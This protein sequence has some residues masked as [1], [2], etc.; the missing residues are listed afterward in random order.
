[1]KISNLLATTC[2][3]VMLLGC[4]GGKTTPNKTSTESNVET[5]ALK[6]AQQDLSAV[7]HA[8]LPEIAIPQAYRVDM[9]IDPQSDTMSGVVEIDVD[10]KI[11]DQLI[12]IHAKEMTVSKATISYRNGT[13]IDLKFNPIPLDEAPSGIAKLT[14]NQNLPTGKAVLKLEYVTPYNQNLNSA[15]KVERGE[16]AY[17]VTQFEPL[18]AREAFPSFD[19]PKYKVPFTLSITSPS[20]NLVIS[21]TPETS[22]CLLYTSPSP[23]DS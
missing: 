17:I 16:D 14:S 2:V 10:V 11:S 3:A 8:Q 21:N 4:G 9:T 1:M 15:Y 12:W 7:P 5:Q 23:R 13:E 18:G 22:T 6:R 20:E 19:E